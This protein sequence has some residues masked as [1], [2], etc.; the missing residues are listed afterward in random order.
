MARRARELLRLFD[1]GAREDEQARNLPY[2]AQRRLEIARALA[3]EPRLLLLDEPAAGMNPQEKG[4]LRALIRR[5]RDEFRVTVLL[6]EHDM[7]LVM[8]ISEHIVVLDH[9]EVIAAGNPE[10]IRSSPAVIAAYLGA[11]EAEVEGGEGTR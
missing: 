1:L 11:E 4:E 5:V 6:I 8:G 3:T 9:G 7:S 2:G 10:T